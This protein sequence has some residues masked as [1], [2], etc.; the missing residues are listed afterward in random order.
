MKIVLDGL[1]N[2]TTSLGIVGL[3]T[4]RSL[5]ALGHT[6]YAMRWPG[7]DERVADEFP[8]WPG[9]AA[10]A[11]IRFCDPWSVECLDAFPECRRRIAYC[12]F[13]FG[14]MEPERVALLNTGRWELWAVSP[15]TRQMLI[16][17]GV[18]I[19]IASVPHGVEAGEPPPAQKGLE[20]LTFVYVA[21]LGGPRKGTDILVKAFRAAFGGSDAAM[22][23][24]KDTPNSPFHFD[25]P[26]IT[27]L[28]GDLPRSELRALL[29]GAH[30]FVAPARMESFGLVGLEAAAAGT[31]M[32]YPW[33]SAYATFANDMPHALPLLEGAWT[34]A[35]DGGRPARHW[36]SNVRELARLLEWIAENGVHRS[37]VP[38]E[39]WE[40]ACRWSWQRTA[41]VV[42]PLLGQ[43][44]P[45]GCA[46]HT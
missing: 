25:D 44:S 46:D 16:N 7:C 2:D 38:R 27:L 6:V 24:L 8:V 40:H 34:M 37:I 21:Q 12:Y 13:D 20:R 23:I 14:V 17:A 31:P 45:C 3:H 18:S 33:H 10:D 9:G 30:Y 35:S 42:V 36:E 29:A 32:I 43:T 26:N 4:C 11:A 19:P 39:V 15:F 1:L 22:L 28:S 5:A 41:E